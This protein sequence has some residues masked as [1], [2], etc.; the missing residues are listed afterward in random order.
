MLF[1]R[2]QKL[3]REINKIDKVLELRNFCWP[4]N[5]ITIFL[6]NRRVKLDLKRKAVRLQ[7]KNLTKMRYLKT[8][9]ANNFAKK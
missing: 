8:C 2:L 5:S 9:E 7:R 4:N 3:D 1:K 6:N